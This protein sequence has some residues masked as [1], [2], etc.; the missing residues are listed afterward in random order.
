MEIDEQ[1]CEIHNSKIETFIARGT[2][3][4]IIVKIHEIQKIRS[5]NRKRIHA[6]KKLNANS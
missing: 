5:C 6:T 2:I 1:M 3:Y 4:K